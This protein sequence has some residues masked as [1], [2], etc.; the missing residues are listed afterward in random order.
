MLMCKPDQICQAS[1]TRGLCWTGYHALQKLDLTDSSATIFSG[2]PDNPNIGHW[3]V[4]SYLKV[5][6]KN[7]PVGFTPPLQIHVATLQ[8]W[9][10]LDWRLSSSHLIRGVP[11]AGATVV[12]YP[13][14]AG[15]LSWTSN[16]NHLTAQIHGR[17]HQDSKHS[18]TC[19]SGCRCAAAASAAAS[20]DACITAK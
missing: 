6:I 20:A 19:Q 2:N 7:A 1:I 3:A 5:F 4:Q 15:G 12:L 13:V 11:T 17:H 14:A 10:R 9:A 16:P 8:E 18:L